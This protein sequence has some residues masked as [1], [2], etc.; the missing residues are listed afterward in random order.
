MSKVTQ[1]L[2]RSPGATPASASLLDARLAALLD[3]IQALGLNPKLVIMGGG[4]LFIGLVGWIN[5]HAKHGLNF[6]YFYLLICAV[7][8]WAGG[9]RAALACSLGS[10]V[11]LFSFEFTQGLSSFLWV[12]ACNSLVR[13]LAFV[14]IGWL[15]A[16]VGRSTRDLRQTVQRRTERWQHEVKQ[17][18]QTAELLTEATEVFRQ[19][20]EN[21][22]D[23]FWVTDPTKTQV[24]YIS[25]EFEELWGRSR[26]TLYV[27]PSVWFE[28]IHHE[29]RERV[30]RAIL[31][32]QVTGQYDEPVGFHKTL[33]GTS[34]RIRGDRRSKETGAD[35]S[36]R[37]R[38][39]RRIENRVSP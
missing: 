8:G 36:G 39:M 7:V 18:E 10:A 34:P 23:V 3:R 5:F 14:S 24:E 37:S 26:H 13:L 16:E 1:S 21:I 25:P 38:C 17:H 22:A 20:T 11:V 19:V 28:G 31:S 33:T 32:K 12:T 30:T 35:C 27:T 6:A 2:D 4:F 29:D 9:S 15:A